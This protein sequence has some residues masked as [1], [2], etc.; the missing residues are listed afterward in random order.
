MAVPKRKTPRSKTHSRRSAN[1]R[2]GTPAHSVC[3]NCGDSKVPHVVCA[4]CGWYKGR[5]AVAV[6]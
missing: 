4:N 3:S 1:R 2:V 5:P 6:D